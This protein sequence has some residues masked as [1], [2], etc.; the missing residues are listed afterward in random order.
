[1]ERGV[2]SCARI[3]QRHAQDRKVYTF[4]RRW[5]RRCSSGVHINAQAIHFDQKCKRLAANPVRSALWRRR[6]RMRLTKWHFTEQTIVG[7][8]QY[9]NVPWPDSAQVPEL[10]GAA[11]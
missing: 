6:L 4:V 5:L 9:V 8:G 10:H 2:K 7:R 3:R 1:F 11:G